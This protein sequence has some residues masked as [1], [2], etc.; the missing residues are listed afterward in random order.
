MLIF[1]P[2]NSSSPMF[3][4]PADKSYYNQHESATKRTLSHA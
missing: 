2:Q 4:D 3:Q 1:S